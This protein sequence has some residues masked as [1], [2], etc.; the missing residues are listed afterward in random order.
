M[1]GESSSGIVNQQISWLFC[2]CA[3]SFSMQS[4]MENLTT[5]LSLLMD[6]LGI[7]LWY[8]DYLCALTTKEFMFRF[9]PVS[10]DAQVSPPS[11]LY[12]LCRMLGE[13]FWHKTKRISFNRCAYQRDQS[14]MNKY[15]HN[16]L[17]KQQEHWNG[18]IYVK[19]DMFTRI[20]MS[21]E[22]VF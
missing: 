11:L 16:N 1:V 10:G 4:A 2:L 18:R 3:E 5:V 9:F 12:A 21:N 13:H 17:H 22:S 14:C 8:W 20:N 6:G 7:I 19:R 15:Y